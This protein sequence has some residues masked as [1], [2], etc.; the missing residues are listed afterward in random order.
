MKKIKVPQ[1]IG[2][3]IVAFLF[4]MLLW[5]IVVNVDD[6]VDYSVYTNVPVTV[7]N[8][9]VVTNMGKVYQVK[10]DIKTIRVTVYA[11]RSVLS[12][13]IKDDIVATADLSQMDLNTYLVPIEVRIPEYDGKYQSAE[14]SPINLQVEI[15]DKTKNTFPISVSVTG[16]PR[17]GY[18]IG[19]MTTNPE[20]ITIGGS[21]SLISSIQKVV[22]KVDV[23]GI[24]ESSVLDA[25]LILYDANGNVMDQSKL[26]N[27]LGDK[28]ISVNVEVLNI[29]AVPLDFQIEGTPASGY[30]YTGW[31]CVPESVQVCGSKEVIAEIN[32]IEIS[33]SEVSIDGANSRLD[34]T[35]DILPY[36]PEGVQLVDETANNVVVTIG[37]EQ[38]GTKTLELS[39]GSIK[40]NN[41]SE[42]LEIAF[43][44]QD[45]LE[46]QFT[47]TKE[48]LEVLD[49]RNAASID[50][51]SYTAPGTYEIPVKIETAP[52]ITLNK[53]PTVTVVL[54]EKKDE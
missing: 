7:T 44:S 12:S 15:D 28:G 25:E 47:G 13:I 1:N 36:L 51:K 33:G 6:P 42:S 52:G 34:I 41:L 54:T 2:L 16:T 4:A 50:L 8:E 20:K 27:N 26:N 43:E 49:I 11:R 46:L 9:A 38:E 21:E 31:S 18:V 14:A 32:S 22:A 19:E 5:L 37:I 48:A 40:V 3:K 45:D 35:V 17:D 23:S 10:D 39:I 29:K 53:K 24:S 30:I